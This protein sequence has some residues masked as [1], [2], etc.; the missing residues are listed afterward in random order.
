MTEVI[1]L[2]AM[3]GTPNTTEDITAADDHGQLDTIVHD[4]GDVRS[5]GAQGFRL[6]SE[7]LLTHQGF[8]R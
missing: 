7:F 5:Q 3:G 4:M 6:K 2:D 1:A 8:A